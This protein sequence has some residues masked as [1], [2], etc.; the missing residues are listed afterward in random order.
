MP[1]LLFFISLLDYE[2]GTLTLSKR[3]ATSE[4]SER[5]RGKTG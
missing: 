1:S 5:R 2:G 4:D 3:E